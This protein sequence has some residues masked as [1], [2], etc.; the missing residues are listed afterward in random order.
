MHLIVLAFL[1]SPQVQRPELCS[2]SGTVVDSITGDPL[3]K[4]D[5]MLEPTD[6]TTTHAATTTADAKGRFAAVDLAP[7]TYHLRAQRN[8]YLEAVSRVRI[9]AGQSLTGLNLKLVPS[10]AISGTVRDSDGEPLEDAH[11]ILARRTARYGKPRVE[12]EDSVDTDD[13]GEYRFR[14]LVAGHYYIGVEPKSRGWDQV[15]HSPN[16]GATV[17]PVATF[18]P[19]VTELAQAAPI[20]VSAGQRVTG[21]DVTLVRSPVFRVRGRVLNVPSANRMTVSLRDSRNGGMRDHG[22]STSTLNATGEFEFRGVPPGSYELSA[23]TGSLSGK[24][25]IVVGASDVEGARL[26][27]APG[28]EVRMRFSA[29]PHETPDVSGIHYSLTTDGRRGFSPA[30]FQAERLTIPNVP[31][32][33]YMLSL[34]GTVLRRFY[35]KSIRAGDADVL[36][37][38]LTVTGPGRV[39]IDVTLASDGAAVQGVVLDKDS[40]PVPD[41]T[42][43]LAPDLRSRDDLFT[44]TTTDQNGHYEFTAVAPGDYKLFAWEEVEEDAWND[45]DFLRQYEKQGAKAALEAKAR[46]SVSVRVATKP[47]R[48]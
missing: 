4:V 17:K 38:G 28:A 3:S 1:F 29:G 24:T 40:Q 10:G 23:G 15:D 37:E 41:A 43:L 6:R 16:A 31:P 20:E 22:L 34:S 2:L 30:P 36:A 19:A 42:V 21:I 25:E 44:S 46:A 35:V 48:P 14:G 27:L 47:D 9:E 39:N 13:R 12:G 26:T 18:Y 32:D 8:G 5:I 7:A 33:H 11:V 45:P